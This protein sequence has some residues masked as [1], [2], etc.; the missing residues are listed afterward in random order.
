MGGGFLG[1]N[2]LVGVDDEIGDFGTVSGG[3]FILSL[4]TWDWDWDW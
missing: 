2:V 1:G 4:Y 3:S